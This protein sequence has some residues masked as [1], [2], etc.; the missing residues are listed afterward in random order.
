MTVN[1]G[2]FLAIAGGLAVILGAAQFVASPVSAQDVYELRASADTNMQTSRTAHLAEYLDEIEKR[3]NGRIKPT[4]YHS[5]QLYRDRDVGKAL[6][7]GSVEMAFPGSWTL[8]GIVSDLDFPGLPSFFG[9]STEDARKVVDGEVGDMINAQLEEKLRSHVLGQWHELEPLHTYSTETE[10]ESF[11]DL[12]GLRVRHP[13]SAMQALQIGSKGATPVV[14]PW[15]DVALA[16]TQGTVDALVSTHNTVASGKLWDSGVHYA[17][18]DNNSRM[19]Q[20]MLVNQAFWD[21]LPPDLQQ[22]MTDTWAEML[23]VFLE[24]IRSSDA[25]Y[26]AVLEEHGITV[27]AP[28][29]EEIAQLRAELAPTEDDAVKELKVNPKISEAIRKIQ[30]TGN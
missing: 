7:Q 22:L 5:A 6:I 3:S 29:A 23:P 18:E 30:S 12:E 14:I 26:R 8:S 2:S 28:S 16:L 9:I 1:R 24:R 25:E 4:L 27:H 10:I 20:V 17:F 11:E 19:F 13:G 15:P 21:S